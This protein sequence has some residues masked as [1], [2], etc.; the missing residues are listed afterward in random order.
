[1]SSP[2][3]GEGKQDSPKIHPFLCSLHGKAW[4]SPQSLSPD[5][6]GALEGRDPAGSAQSSSWSEL[7]ATPKECY[8]PPSLPPPVSVFSLYLLVVWSASP[9]E[10]KCVWF[11]GPEP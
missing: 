6:V 3:P 11:P 8:S 10:A 7:I 5:Q 1:M 4:K 2:G 9:Q